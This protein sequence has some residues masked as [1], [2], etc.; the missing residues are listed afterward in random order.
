[1][2][3]PLGLQPVNPEPTKD[4]LHPSP[5]NIPPISK[6]DDATAG[7][8]YLA[9]YQQ[10][11]AGMAAAK[12]GQIAMAEAKVKAALASF[13]HI[14]LTFPAWHPEMVA[15]R[16]DI[17]AESVGIIERNAA[18]SKNASPEVQKWIDATTALQ[19]TALRQQHKL[20]EELDQAANKGIKINP[21][22]NPFTEPLQRLEA[23]VEAQSPEAIV[24]GK[25]KRLAAGKL[26]VESARKTTAERDA[27]PSIV[28]V[29]ADGSLTYARSADASAERTPSTLA[30]LPQ[31]LGKLHNPTAL[32][33]LRVSADASCPYEQLAEIM[34]AL[35]QAGYAWLNLTQTE[36]AEADPV[37]TQYLKVTMN[38]ADGHKLFV[39][40]EYAA[41]YYK[42]KD[43]AT[44]LQN[45]I[46][47]HPTWRT[48]EITKLHQKISSLSEDAR[49]AEMKRRSAPDT[50]P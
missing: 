15:G 25:N 8:L 29:N 13:R 3:D 24:E 41:A 4:A 22:E 5:R 38:I 40:K 30:D 45:I 1:M 23:Q 10:M 47:E 6:A 26:L 49:Q 42:L 16:V 7:N 27:Y 20:W 31:A 9:A 12:D 48:E 46:K 34:L 37:A 21:K 35:K 17:L 33:T 11:S 39:A 44:Q 28:Y 18:E 2:A 43:A 32:G 36:H 19:L 50:K 14:Q